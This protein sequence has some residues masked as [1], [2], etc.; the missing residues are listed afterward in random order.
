MYYIQYKIH[1]SQERSNPYHSCIQLLY[2]C[3]L[4]RG[5]AL[6]SPSRFPDLDFDFDLD[7][8]LD[9]DLDLD[10]SILSKSV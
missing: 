8:D 2:C 10:L 3:Y 7:L 9:P 1:Q 6:S 5:F 4:R